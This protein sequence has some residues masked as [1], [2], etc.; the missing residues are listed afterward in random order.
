M[1]LL[2]TNKEILSPNCKII[3]LLLINHNKY[4]TLHV[5]LNKSANNMNNISNISNIN[6]I[7]SKHNYD[8]PQRS[9]DN[10]DDRI[11]REREIHK[12]YNNKNK[13]LDNVRRVNEF[14]KSNYDKYS[15]L[16]KDQDDFIKP[17]VKPSREDNY[18]KNED[19]KFEE[20]NKLGNSTKNYSTRNHF[21]QNTNPVNNNFSHNNLKN[22]HNISPYIPK[23]Y[24]NESPKQ[25]SNDSPDPKI[26]NSPKKIDPFPIRSKFQ[27]E[28]RIYR[29]PNNINHSMSYTNKR[30][31][32]SKAKNGK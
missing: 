12:S 26:K 17:I 8:I 31:N 20:F 2:D 30:E 14:P 32:N 22:P 7:D 24:F 4:K 28:K 1:F 21:D 6:N 10:Y 23:K 19:R 13:S 9:Y 27:S 11:N 29:E 18:L 25:N 5:V 3:E 16:N 15:N